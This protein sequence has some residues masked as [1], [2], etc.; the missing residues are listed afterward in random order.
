M[1]A[2]AFS[3]GKN[4]LFLFKLYF[5]STLYHL[6]EVSTCIFLMTVCCSLWLIVGLGWWFGILRDTAPK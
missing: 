5:S 2:S 1:L 3:D 4:L 6:F